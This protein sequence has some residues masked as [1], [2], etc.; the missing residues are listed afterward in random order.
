MQIFVKDL[1]GKTLTLDVNKGYTI[2]NIKNKIKDKLGVP[3][4]EQNLTYGG[5]QLND[6]KTLEYYDITEEATIQMSMSLKGGVTEQEVQAVLQML[7]DQVTSLRPL[8]RLNKN[9]LDSQII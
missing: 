2:I 6:D 1:N 3:I 5:K 7:S 8:L 4:Q 9:R